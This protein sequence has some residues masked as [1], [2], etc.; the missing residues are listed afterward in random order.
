MKSIRKKET[1]KA[2][3]AIPYPQNEDRLSMVQEASAGVYA[4][5]FFDL[6]SLFQFKKEELANLFH[7]S[8]KSLMRY[9]ASK[10]KLNAA[11][12][13]HVLKMISLHNHGMEVFGDDNALHR[14]LQK[15]AYGLGNKIPFQ[16]MNTSS[17]IDLIIN[18]LKRIEWGDLA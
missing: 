3:E 10:Q 7:V 2:A 12:S 9:H 15:P 13:E 8:L 6:A 17:G 18:E 4:S 16:L 14:W 11:Q 5:R 1:I